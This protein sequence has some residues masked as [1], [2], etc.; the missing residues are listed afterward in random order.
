M[1]SPAGLSPAT[2][3]LGHSCSV[4]ELWGRGKLLVRNRRLPGLSWLPTST[5]LASENCGF[6]LLMQPLEKFL[7]T[8]VSQDGFHCV[9]CIP[10]LVMTLG[11]V[12]EIL[13]GMTRRHDLGSTFAARHHVVPAG[14]NLTLT[15]DARLGHKR[16]AGSIP[17]QSHIENG[18]RSGN[19]TH[20]SVILQPLSRGFARLCRTS[21]ISGGG[22]DI[23]TR[24]GG[25]P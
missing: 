22:S 17:N 18:R 8:S 11:L 15:E 24:E 9:E 4:F 1:V 12:N 5:T 7:E 2:W 23:R 21:S 14:R 20:D 19:R 10:K 16:S 25:E 13:A 6:M 3:S